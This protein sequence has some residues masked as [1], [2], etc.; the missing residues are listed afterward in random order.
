[1]GKSKKNNNF[2]PFPTY[3]FLITVAKNGFFVKE[4]ILERSL[5]HVDL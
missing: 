3:I 5:Y 4:E 1:M 2:Y